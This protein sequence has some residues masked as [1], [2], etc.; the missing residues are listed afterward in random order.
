MNVV[1]TGLLA[2]PKVFD[3]ILDPAGDESF[4]PFAPMVLVEKEARL[5][6]VPA[7]A[8]LLLPLQ[9]GLAR[10]FGAIVGYAA[11]RLPVARD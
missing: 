6:V 5:D 3:G 7:D 4:R 2:R 10:K 8:T 11:H 1:A 9:D